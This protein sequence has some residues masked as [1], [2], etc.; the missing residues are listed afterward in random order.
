MQFRWN[1]I[2]TLFI[3]VVYYH[4]CLQGAH[5][6]VDVIRQQPE[7]LSEMG[8]EPKGLEAWAEWQGDTTLWSWK[9]GCLCSSDWGSTK[10]VC[11]S[12]QRYSLWSLLHGVLH[13]TNQKNVEQATGCVSHPNTHRINLWL[14]DISQCPHV[15]STGRT[16]ALRPNSQGTFTARLLTAP[17]SLWEELGRSKGDHYHDWHHWVFSKVGVT[18]CWDLLMLKCPLL[19]APYSLPVAY[20]VL[21]HFPYVYNL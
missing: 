18:C 20:T 7:V 6:E 8:E 15:G 4:D 16:R 11:S 1:C 9:S 14:S 10:N 21:P 2:F 13:G 17:S 3:Q 12:W 5:Y 19:I